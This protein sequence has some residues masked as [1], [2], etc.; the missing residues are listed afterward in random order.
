MASLY[1]CLPRFRYSEFLVQILCLIGCVGIALIN[2]SYSGTEAKTFVESSIELK[3][4]VIDI[5][6]LSVTIFK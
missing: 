5:R 6:L 3:R 4:S 1:L 2:K